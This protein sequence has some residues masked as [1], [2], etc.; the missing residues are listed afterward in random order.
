MNVALNSELLED[1]E[2]YKYLVS[3]ITVHGGRER[4]RGEV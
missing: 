1:V 3:K 4:E 2:C